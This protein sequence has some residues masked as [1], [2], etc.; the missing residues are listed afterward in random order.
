[1][2][3]FTFHEVP[4][5]AA[6][7]LIPKATLLAVSELAEPLMYPRV[8]RL[9]TLPFSPSLMESLKTAMLPDRRIRKKDHR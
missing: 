8:I 2:P 1:M 4:V 6:P 9:K 7:P 3:F 5:V